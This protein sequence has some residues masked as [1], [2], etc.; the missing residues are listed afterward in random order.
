MNHWETLPTNTWETEARAIA[1][2]LERLPEHGQTDEFRTL[3][4]LDRLKEQGLLSEAVAHVKEHFKSEMQEM[5]DHFGEDCWKLLAVLELFDPETAEHCVNTYAI[6]KNKV[7]M[8]LWNGIVLTDAFKQEQVDLP[9]F[10]RACILHDIGK[11]EVPH[12]VLVT[13]V[14]DEQCADILN[15]HRDDVLLPRL[16]LK[17]GPQFE[18]PT[19]IQDGPSL[20]KYLYN[21]LHLRPQEITP[22]KLLLEHPLDEEINEQLSHC[23]CSLEDS[24]LEIMRTHDAY[25]AQILAK[26]GYPVEGDIA[27]AH[28]Q[29]A[30]LEKKYHITI[31]TMQVSVDLADIIHLADVENAML[32][33]RHYKEGSTPLKALQVLAIHAKQG[34]I[35]DYIAYLWIAD[36]MLSLETAQL[37]ATDRA[38]YTSLAAFLDSS[39]ARH[40]GW[41]N[42]RDTNNVDT[43]KLA[44]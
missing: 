13:R 16:R 31:G 11:I 20:L 24:L 3:R 1:C 30:S 26:L 2:D 8:K 44:A 29:H 9:Q 40:L 39:K 35:Q 17:Y 43:Q 42:W 10:Y 41:P 36:E 28:H 6:A 21:T 18:L 37:D 27:G 22:I 14:P 34:L 32:S 23:G 15:E 38:L 33:K 25:S 4:I 19:T 12:A 7:E 5:Q